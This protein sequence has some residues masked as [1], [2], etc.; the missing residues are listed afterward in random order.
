M[1]QVDG[2]MKFDRE[3]PKTRDTKERI[4]DYHEVYKPLDKERVKQQASRCMDCG[5]PF[6]HNGCPLGNNIPD[7]NDAVYLGKWE[8]AIHILSS[9]NNFPEFTGR[10][11]PAPCEASCV[12]SINNNPVTIE[13]I[14]K[15]IAEQ[16]FEKGYIKPNP[17]KTRTGK[18]IAVVGSG[19]AGLAAAAQLNK[20]G[21]WVTVFERSDR[22]GGLLRYGIPDF[23]LEKNIVERRIR[24]M[25]QE[26]IIFR[27]DAHVGVNISAKHLKDEFDAIVMCGGAS[28]PRDLSIPGR[29]LKGVHF[30]MEFLPQQN[31][32]VSG[33]QIFSAEILATRKNVLV[34]GGGDT[35]S[36]CVG[37]SNR[38]NAKSVTQI[39]LLSKPPLTRS[40]NNPWPLWPMVL[41]TSSSHEEGVDRKWA[42]LTKE[43]LGDDEGNLTGLKVADIKW[44][45]NTQGK[46]GFEEIPGSERIMPCE[47]A[48][49]AIGFIGAEPGGMVEELKLA[50]DERGNIKTESYMTSNEGV[51]A[52]GDIRRGQSLVVWAISEGRETARAVDLWLM[53]S[54]SLESKD[55][56]FVHLTEEA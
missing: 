52:A 55:E 9:T 17:P 3:M 20:A 32:R 18:R 44:S 53:G 56:S 22:I 31:K 42:I 43:F 27:T 45:A 8:E 13:Y 36:D 35:G 16:A 50:L 21:H 41:M 38:Q 23:K 15:T 54:S 2:F 40:E 4:K 6:C 51:F 12:L 28:A 5:V 47:L 26:G 33:D 39:E 46:M 14:E 7:F 30:A 37:T 11:C 10:I 29:Q 24:L 19:P 49:L 34:I 48:L 1:G 25:E